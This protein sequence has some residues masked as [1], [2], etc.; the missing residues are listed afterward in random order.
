MRARLKLQLLLPLCAAQVAAFLAPGA[1]ALAVGG[2]IISTNLA[3]R[4]QRDSAGSSSLAARKKGRMAKGKLLENL[5]DEQ[6]E[7]DDVIRLTKK[8]KSNE[9]GG[10]DGT[11][12]KSKLAAE[13][14]TPWRTVSTSVYTTHSAPASIE[15][16]VSA[17]LGVLQCT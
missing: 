5:E 1:P 12:D 11:F 15:W 6:E 16:C 4:R 17:L 14:S 9:A 8:T 10:G 7:Q 2:G 13:V 3:T